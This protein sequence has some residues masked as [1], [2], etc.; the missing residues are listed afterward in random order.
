MKQLRHLLSLKDLSGKEI[1]SLVDLALKIKKSQRKYAKTLSG[2]NLLMFFEKPSLRTRLSFEVAMLQLGGHAIFYDMQG[3][4]LGKG[5]ETIED[6]ARVVS[7]Y[8]NAVMAR[9]YSHE[10]L[11]KMALNSHIPVINGLTDFSHPCQVLSDLLTVREKFRKLKGLKL[12]YLGDANN[13]VTHSLLFALPRVGMH[14]TVCCPN[15]KEFMPNASVVDAAKKYAKENSTKL[16]ISSNP[17]E[18]KGS[19][20]VYT[21]SWMSYHIPK[22]QEARRDTALKKYQVSSKTMQHA[23][24]NSVF[25]HCLPAKRGEE[26]TADVIDGRQSIVLDQAENRLHMQKAILVWLMK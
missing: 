10:D 26:V 8:M 4:P 5:K 24:K 11:K 16:V 14:L 7:R 3:S 18:A 25:M 9:L 1:L 17:D 19:D 15:N 21:D 6:T 20:V 13:N 2:K 22:D 23:D 12:V